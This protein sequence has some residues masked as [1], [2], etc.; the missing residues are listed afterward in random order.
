MDA[1]RLCMYMPKGGV[2]TAMQRH[3]NMKYR[4]LWA[5]TY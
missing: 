4:Y 3:N 5:D 2:D 1:Y